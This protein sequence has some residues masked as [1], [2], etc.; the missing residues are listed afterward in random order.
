M[1]R[2]RRLKKPE[3]LN[4]VPILDSVFIFIF[5]L[6]MSAQ[7]IDVYE[8]GTSVPMTVEM[9][10]KDEKDPLNLTMVISE[11]K[12]VIESGLRN[13][14]RREFSLS[15]PG[16]LRT[17]LREIKG[18]HPAEE[19][20]IVKSDPKI[21]FQTVVKALDASRSERKEEKLFEKVIFDGKGAN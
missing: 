6:L 12:L 18:R 1:K 20:L 4:L 16:E 9:T 17:Y 14:V 2:V 5:F 7:F 19:T 15:S 8:I 11:E 21:P 3:K 13:P 10:E